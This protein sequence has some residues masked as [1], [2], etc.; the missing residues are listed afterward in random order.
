M[1]AITGTVYGT[2]LFGHMSSSY[3]GSCLLTVENLHF[4]SNLECI[5][6]KILKLTF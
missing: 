5:G 4:Y 1:T 2:H 6:L 3:Q